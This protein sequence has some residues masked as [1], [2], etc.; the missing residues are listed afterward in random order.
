MIKETPK[1]IELKSSSVTVR[2]KWN[3][4]KGAKLAKK[5]YVARLFYVDETGAKREQSKEFAKRKDA[6]DHVR[7]QRLKFERSG[8]REI[9]AEKMT[10][11]DLANHF[12][13]H[14]AKQAEYAEGRK[15]AGLRS[16]APVLGYVETLRKRFGQR[17]LKSLTYGD[18]RDFRSERINTPVVKE[19]KVIIPLTEEERKKL[20]TRKKNRIEFTE[21]ITPRKIA[22]ANRELMTLRR[23]LNVAQIEGWIAKSPFNAGP[24]L[25]NMADE[26]MRTRILT[27][28]EEKR[29]LTACESDER[30]HLRAIV[31]CLL[32]TG[33]RLNEALTLTWATVDFANDL[34]HITAF[35]SKTAK[36]K[37]VP[38]SRRL[39]EELE[40]L[41]EE[42][43][44]L[45]VINTRP[46][47]DRVFGIENN[48]NRSWRT[49]RK[50]AGLEDVRI[51]DLRHTFG[52]RLDRSGFTQAQ[53][54]RMLGHQQVHTTFRYTN[55]DKDLLKDVRSAVE[56]FH[57][58]N[59]AT[60]QSETV[61]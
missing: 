37:T 40:R 1:L 61:H 48:V 27:T 39:R 47:T 10:F 8:G 54:A 44:V 18:M 60:E 14:Y 2:T 30:R 41:L 38:I 12:V 59:G 33:L 45:D 43:K 53:I 4:T 22:S 19:I 32:D 56:S 6:D 34:I 17:K 57:T 9:E 58:P 51:H 16:L 3:R 29:L 55:P 15:I 52:T 21:K 5:M 28:D 24:S 36:P 7:Q 20:K 42:R 11:E 50:L 46:S 25:V 13:R 26:T 49:A 23:M 35:N 31:I